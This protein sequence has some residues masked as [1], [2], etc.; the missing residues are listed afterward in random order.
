MNH[1]GEDVVELTLVVGARVCAC[2]QLCIH[3]L[4]YHKVLV[5]R[6]LLDV[7]DLLVEVAGDDEFC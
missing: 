6:K 1:V 7:F 2:G 4:R 5:F 3:V